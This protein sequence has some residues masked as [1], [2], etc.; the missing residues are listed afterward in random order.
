MCY[1]RTFFFTFFL[2]PMLLLNNSPALKTS[3]KQLFPK[4]PNNS[5]I[6]N[7]HK[8]YSFCIP[9]SSLLLIFSQ[10]YNSWANS[11]ARSIG[12]FSVLFPFFFACWLLSLIFLPQNTI[13][14]VDAHFSSQENEKKIEKKSGKRTISTIFGLF[15]SHWIR[16]S[17][18]SLTLCCYQMMCSIPRDSPKRLSVLCLC[19]CRSWRKKDKAS[20]KTV[21]KLNGNIDERHVYHVSRKS[22][23]FVNKTINL[24]AWTILSQ[25]VFKMKINMD[26]N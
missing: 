24:L 7:L 9:F 15:L 26:G 10:T 22:K 6:F 3:S 13:T 25:H 21:F 5:N 18:Y 11:S 1:F 19:R 4:L 2:F 14:F 23:L 12:T 16:K 20:N 17:F 8:I